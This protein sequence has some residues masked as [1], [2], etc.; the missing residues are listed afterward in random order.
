MA[1]AKT[2]EE[3]TPE[4]E[5]SPGPFAETE[6][7]HENLVETPRGTYFCN[8]CKKHLISVNGKFVVAP[9]GYAVGKVSQPVG[10]IP[11]TP[12]TTEPLKIFKLKNKIFAIV[13]FAVAAAISALFGFAFLSTALILVAFWYALPSQF[14]IMSRAKKTEGGIEIGNEVG[15]LYLKSFLKILVVTFLVLEFGFAHVIHKVIPLIIVFV[16]YLSLPNKYKPDQPY[17]AADAWFRTLLGFVLSFYMLSFL[18]LGGASSIYSGITVIILIYLSALI[19]SLATASIPQ[20]AVKILLTALIVGAVGFAFQAMFIGILDKPEFSIFLLSLAFFATIPQT[21]PQEDKKQVVIAGVFNKVSP[22]TVL[23]AVNARNIDDVG[24]GMFLALV[25]YAGLPVLLGWTKGAFMISY[26]AVW[27]LGLFMGTVGGREGRP[28]IGIIVIFFSLIAFSFQ[29]T[30]QF[31]TAIFGPYWAS[32]YNFGT[33]F[34]APIGQAFDSVGKNIGDAW[35]VITCGPGCAVEPP[36]PSTAEKSTLALEFENFEATNYRK[37]SPEIDPQLPLVGQIELTNKGD[38]VARNV[39]VKLKNIKLA[40]PQKVSANIPGQ[41]ILEL[42]N[43]GCVFTSCLGSD[44]RESD[45]SA[46]AV[47]ICNWKGDSLPDDKKLLLFKC[48][49]KSD[50]EK[51]SGAAV[52]GVTDRDS[53]GT[54]RTFY[55][56]NRCECRDPRNGNLV[57]S[58]VDCNSNCG[59]L[60]SG[61]ILGK[62]QCRAPQWGYP[63]AGNLNEITECETLQ[64]GCGGAQCNEACYGQTGKIIKPYQKPGWL[65]TLGF[66]YNFTYNTNVSLPV[67]LM[68]K[69]EFLKKYQSKQITLEDKTAVYSGGPVSIGIYLGQQPLRTSESITGTIYVVNNGQGKASKGT[70]IRVHIPNE[71]DADVQFSQI[72][73]P[74]SVPQIFGT[75]NDVSYNSATS[76]ITFE[77]KD[78]LK[79]GQQGVLTFSFGYNIK[80][81]A[82]EKNLIFAGSM[83]YTYSSEKTFQF[84]K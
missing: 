60:V 15:W 58:D 72:P 81:S 47:P 36:P 41:G 82:P 28:Y 10:S 76:D 17:K 33:T 50:F 16:A 80:G 32:V 53:E 37:A 21:E 73:K 35:L 13:I 27:L 19:A 55:G 38:F 48:G 51:W 30:G 54:S 52:A 49:N 6:C 34:G 5:A 40:D 23:N 59:T 22:S 83:D 20:K 24:S 69:Q 75:I 57:K 84:P 66:D 14:D 45:F 3:S 12:E 64:G 70:K 26:A 46:N 71:K 63:P 56:L 29:Y 7:P 44:E 79:T 77:L 67:R 25:L 1:A 2:D 42:K 11:L 78:D 4:V 74:Q 62:C 61:T 68:D 39:V 9:H 65:V 31:G 18:S 8:Q 43:D